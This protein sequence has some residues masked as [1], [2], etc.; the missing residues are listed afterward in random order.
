M[1][2]IYLILNGVERFTIELMRVNK[3]YGSGVVNLTQA[4]IIALLLIASG[5]MLALY[6]KWKTNHQPA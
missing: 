5:I 4:E 3:Q 2:A 6:A 1:F